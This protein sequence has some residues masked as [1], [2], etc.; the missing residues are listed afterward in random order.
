MEDRQALLLKLTRK[1]VIC[2]GTTLG[3]LIIFFFSNHF[4]SNSSR[5]YL[6]LIVFAAGLIGG[7]VSIQQRIHRVSDLELKHLSQSWSSVLLIPIYGGIFA[8]AIHVIFLSE[9]ITGGLFPQY[10]VLKF[11]T[12]A[13]LADFKSFFED[14]LPRSGQDAAKMIFWAFCAGFSERLVPQ[15]IQNV[16]SKT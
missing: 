6:T 13:T 1:L 4:S 3:V 16:Q 9:I 14:T 5:S 11:S 7:F 2:T 8:I 10:S 15:I 12:P